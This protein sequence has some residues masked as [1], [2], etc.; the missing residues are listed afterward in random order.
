MSYRVVPS[1][2]VPRSCLERRS[3]FSRGSRILVAL[4]SPSTAL[5]LSSCVFRV[6]SRLSSAL[7]SCWLMLNSCFV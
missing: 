2:N 6:C 1:R 3:P 4:D 5:T 7:S